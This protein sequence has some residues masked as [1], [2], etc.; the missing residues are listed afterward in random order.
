MHTYR[1]VIM[2]LNETQNKTRFSKEVIDDILLKQPTVP[3]RINF[4]DRKSVV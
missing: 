2:S 1:A 3:V 4:V